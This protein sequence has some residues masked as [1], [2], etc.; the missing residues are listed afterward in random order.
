[1]DVKVDCP[2]FLSDKCGTMCREGTRWFSKFNTLETK[3]EPGHIYT[4]WLQFLSLILISCAE[5]HQKLYNSDKALMSGVLINLM[6][7]SLCL[8]P[9]HYCLKANQ[10]P[11]PPSGTIAPK[12]L[13][14]FML[15]ATWQQI[16]IQRNTWL[17]FESF[18]FFAQSFT[19]LQDESSSKKLAA[20]WSCHLGLGDVPHE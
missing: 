7:L 3:R 4:P 11:L 10:C 2:A 15:L 8:H 17:C 20:L 16:T 14:R 9:R 5:V 1:M 18:F 13:T 12:Q 19:E 6:S